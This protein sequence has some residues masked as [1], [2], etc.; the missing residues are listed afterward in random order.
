MYVCTS[1]EEIISI[2]KSLYESCALQYQLPTSNTD[3]NNSQR[4]PLEF[5][6][7]YF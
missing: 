2:Q 7:S 4:K 5:P 1:T 6:L 3:K